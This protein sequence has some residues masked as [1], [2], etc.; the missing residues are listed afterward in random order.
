MNPLLL[1]SSCLDALMGV[2]LLLLW[3]QDRSHT[4]VRLWGWSAILLALGLT[5]GVALA[6]LPGAAGLWH[7]LQALGASAA[8]M[9]SLFLQIG[10]A[11]RYRGLRWQRAMWLPSL[12]LM[13]AVLMALAKTE[14]RLAVIAATAFLVT[15][16][17]LCAAW[18]WR[19]G[20]A[21][22]R[23]V[24]GCFLLSALVHASSPFLDAQGASPITH[25]LGLFVQTALSLSLI[26]ISVA[27][28][29]GEAQRQ[30]ERFTRLAEHSLQ[31]QVVM[32]EGQ[33]LYANPAARA[34]F[35][36]GE[37]PQGDLLQAL[38]LPELHE[39][40]RQ[41]HA[42][43][44]ADPQARIEWEEPRLDYDGRPLHV[45]GL[46][47]HLEWDGQPAELLV[48]VDETERHAALEALRRQALRDE[49][50]G[51]PNRNFAVERLRQLTGLGAPAFTLVS[52]DLDRFQLVNETL[53]PEMGDAL[54]QAVAQRL[55][56]QLPPQATVARLGEDQFVML[57]EGAS[58]RAEALIFAERLLALMERPFALDGAELFVHMSVGV[59][60]FPQD[61][62]DGPSLLRAADAAMH[63]AKTRAGATYA[64][65]DAA[66]NSAAQAR[67]VAEQAL[68]RA[69]EQGEF[70][71]EY[72][73]K[74]EAVSR[75][76]C[77]FEALVRWQRPGIG[78]VSPAEFVPAA[79]RTGL[80]K[81]LGDRIV[82]IATQQLRDWLDRYGRALPVAIN[83][84][85]LQ[86]EDAGFVGRLL[87]A[88]DDREL[89]HELLQI[90]IT[91]TAAIGHV[92]RV[93]PQLERLRAAGVLCSLDDFGTGQ[94]SLTMLRQL[95]IHAMKL[96]RSM[97]EPLPD[98]DA[99]AVVQATCALG[100]SLR[101]EIVAEGVETEEQ[102]LAVE[103]L[104]CSQL[105]GYFI[106]RPQPAERAGETLRSYLELW[107]P[108]PP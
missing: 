54:L 47:S 79:E 38:V 98:P 87:D 27:R 5:L 89:P 51:L 23:W 3:R 108:A 32:R 21:A 44:L 105:Q 83:V 94:S 107:Q 8:L 97:I 17:L 72:Q 70:F 100:Q 81:A 76:L 106:S 14:H 58:G 50:T 16:N 40:V 10:G 95:P 52:A 49:L 33:I 41:R 77:G 60:L 57:V 64:F 15:G 24:A 66:M 48:M 45:R 18:L 29:H 35:G 91:E 6:G 101:L 37:R 9:G 20:S 34:M 84:S 39:T 4:H 86:F 22:E 69:L 74:V 36:R 42:Q 71:L 62:S 31:G 88:L 13:M 55:C 104:G 92:E 26:L 46:S 63:R 73:P 102:A 30:A 25:T 61:G 67:L 65:F 53:G 59:A 96:D 7:D 12:A 103:A 93:L 1:I 28:A 11:R 75:R 43:V 85:P 56:S 80:I 78:P 68:S 90:E 99:S 19:G 82:A 2:A